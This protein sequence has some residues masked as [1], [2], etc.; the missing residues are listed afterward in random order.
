MNNFPIY[1]GSALQWRK[2]LSIA[3]FY[4]GH[5]LHN[6]LS[7]YT[8]QNDQISLTKQGN[9]PKNGFQSHITKLTNI[10]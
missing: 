7:S 4:C 3:L 10:I 5:K 1:G 9:Q 8:V 6:H 2:V